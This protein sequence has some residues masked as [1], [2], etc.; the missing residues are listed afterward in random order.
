MSDSLIAVTAEVIQSHQVGELE[1]VLT[2]GV[3]ICVY[4]ALAGRE[5]LD[6]CFHFSHHPPTPN[7]KAHVIYN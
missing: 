7:L 2:C 5:Q 1:W 3:R 4:M 6:Q